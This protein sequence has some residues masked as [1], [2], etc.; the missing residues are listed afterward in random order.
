MSPILEKNDRDLVKLSWATMLQELNTK[1][2]I[3]ANIDYFNTPA[4]VMSEKFNFKTI[5]LRLDPRK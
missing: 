4:N 5:G 3:G 1:A 2:A